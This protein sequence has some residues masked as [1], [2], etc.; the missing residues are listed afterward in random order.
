MS[1][2]S[3]V[4]DFLVSGGKGLANGMTRI[5]NGSLLTKDSACNGG[6]RFWWDVAAPNLLSA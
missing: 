5:I 4:D 6:T 3:F 1:N 2:Q